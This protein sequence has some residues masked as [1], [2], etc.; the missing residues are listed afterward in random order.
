V[1]TAAGARSADTRLTPETPLDPSQSQRYY[2]STQI[3]VATLIGGPLAG[4][5]LASCD[6]ALFGHPEK[7]RVI[8][9]ISCVAIIG[10]LYLGSIVPPQASRTALPF[11]AVVAYR[12]YATYAFDPTIAQRKSEGWLQYS[13]WRAVGISLAVLIAMLVLMFI[14]VSLFNIQD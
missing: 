1:G 10:L 11:I 12:V 14:A 7:G 4:G 5:Y 8:L 6:H 13:W 9:I 3:A 2:S